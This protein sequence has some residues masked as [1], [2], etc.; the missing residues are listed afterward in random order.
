MT[1]KPVRNVAA[2]R[3]AKLLTLARQRGEVFQFLLGRWIVERFLY[4][5]T[6][7][8]QKDSFILKG[9]MLFPAWDGGRSA[10]PAVATC[11]GALASQARSPKTEKTRHRR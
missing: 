3:H 4:R 2:S 6:R 1:I 8:D 9:A 7:S 5:L 10:A 11:H